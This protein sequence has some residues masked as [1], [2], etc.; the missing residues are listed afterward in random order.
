MRG[1]LFLGVFALL[2]LSLSCRKI[3]RDTRILLHIVDDD[4][5]KPIQDAQVIFYGVTNN[6]Y[7]QQLYHEHATSNMNG[8]IDRTI[9]TYHDRESYSGWSAVVFTDDHTYAQKYFDTKLEARNNITVRMTKTAVVNLQFHPAQSSPDLDHV[10]WGVNNVRGLSIL[11]NF[12]EFHSYCK[13]RNL[14][15]F[16]DQKFSNND[17]TIRIICDPLT[18]E[19]FYYK[20]PSG[21]IREHCSLE[22]GEV[23]NVD[24]FY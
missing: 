13:D 22:K 3:F 11:Y 24:I 21:V 14:V 10:V 18:T 6:L 1:K 8:E 15:S 9:S 2:I 5:G 20:T 4:T 7:H 12:D 23:K 16:S 19:Y 17:T